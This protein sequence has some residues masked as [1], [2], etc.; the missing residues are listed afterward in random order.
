M[1]PIEWRRRKG[2]HRRHH[3]KKRVVCQRL[4]DKSGDLQAE[5]SLRSL[6]YSDLSRTA[7]RHVPD[8]RLRT[9]VHRQEHSPEVLSDHAEER[10]LNAGEKEKRRH[11]R[12][13]ARSEE[14]RVGKEGRYRRAADRA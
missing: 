6:N 2:V 7:S 9:L 10:E 1:A 14:R 4:F 5:P 12:A 13:P 8:D 3:L 11:E